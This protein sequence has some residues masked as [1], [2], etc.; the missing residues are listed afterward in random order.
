[1]IS[2]QLLSEVLGVK[3]L[4]SDIGLCIDK[5]NVIYGIIINDDDIDYYSI[6]IYEFAHKCK[7]WAY[8]Q[9]YIINSGR[10]T[11]NDWATTVYKVLEFNPYIKE[12][13]HTWEIIEPEAI[14]K[15]TE[16]VL[17]FKGII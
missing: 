17:R 16:W 9:G 3:N 10:T 2:K 8:V 6:N 12:V 7:E 13:Y 1:M 11:S 5:V 14:F 4:D 15:A